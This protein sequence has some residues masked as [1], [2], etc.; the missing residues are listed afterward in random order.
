MRTVLEFTRMSKP[1]YEIVRRAI[2]DD[3]AFRARVAA[4]A[5]EADVGRAGWLWLHRPDGWETD[6]AWATADGH[7]RGRGLARLQ[8][9]RDGAE[10]AAARHGAAAEAAE[11][12]RDR[13]LQQLAEARAQAQA[14][15]TERDEL[16]AR[17]TGLADERAAAVRALKAQEGDLAEARRDLR[18]AR[19]ATRQA[20]AE[21]LAGRATVSPAAGVRPPETTGK[22]SR[23][24]ARRIPSGLPPGVREGSAEASRLLVSSGRVVVVVD[25]YN[26]AR[27]AWSGLAPEEERRR[28]VAM[29]E[30]VQARSGGTV[31]VV[32]DGEDH[33]V[34]PLASRTVRVR[35]SPTGVT[36]DRVI[37][38]LL[39]AETAGRPVA[40]VS[41]DREVAA[42]AASRGAHSL[43]SSD[44][45]TAA[46]R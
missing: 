37:A 44:F 32:F 38:H 25:G 36:A 28:T 40:V 41:S 20:E 22:A 23:G 3:P 6:P 14:A 16:A 39:A 15:V 12:A 8:R 31:I 33:T 24:L 27:A 5:E 30:E 46:G 1:A 10:A 19:E 34:A 26:L 2:D 29:L 42:D 13:A 43:S 9:E 35:F 7:D 11:R 45:L 21:L 4:V 17:L 18:V